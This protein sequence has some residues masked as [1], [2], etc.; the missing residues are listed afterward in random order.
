MTAYDVPTQAQQKRNEKNA[1]QRAYYTRR[2]T[3]D[4]YP[5]INHPLK[6]GKRLRVNSGVFWEAVDRIDRG[7]TRTIHDQETF[8]Q[9]KEWAQLDRGNLEKFRQGREERKQRRRVAVEN[10][11]DLMRGVRG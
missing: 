4:A 2:K 11:T 9:M 7:Y 10:I 6:A 1:R 3:E 5:I 8:D